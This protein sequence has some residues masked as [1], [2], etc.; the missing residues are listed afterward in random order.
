M[1]GLRR[2]QIGLAKFGVGAR[3]EEAGWPG[4]FLEQFDFNPLTAIS[5]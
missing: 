5:A 1:Y 3:Y 2:G 4:W